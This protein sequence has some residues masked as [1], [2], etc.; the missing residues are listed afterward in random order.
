[1]IDAPPTRPPAARPLGPL[2]LGD[3][4]RRNA[5]LALFQIA[6]GV[7]VVFTLSGLLYLDLWQS[8]GTDLSRLVPESATLFLTT[9]PPRAARA[10][11]LSL[12]RWADP[13]ALERAL[14]ETSYLATAP[15]G[16]VFGVP[17]DVAREILVSTDGLSVALLPTDHG[18]APLLF[19]ELRD[20]LKRRR[21]LARLNPLLDTVDRHVGFR[22]D[23]VRQSPWQRLTGLDATAPRVVAMEPYVIF[24]W[25]GD[26]ALDRVLEARVAGETDALRWRE[27]FE[28]IG[29]V[30]DP[31]R[32]RALIDPTTLWAFAPG[33]TLPAGRL[34]SALSVLAV[35]ADLADRDE[36]L[37]VRALLRDEARA[38]RL[39]HALP[40]LPHALVELAPSDAPWVLSVV[41]DK[42]L[43]TLSMARD[44]L[45]GAAADLG[46]DDALRPTLERLSSIELE[47][48]VRL[49]WEVAAAFAGE[50]AV[51]AMPRAAAGDGPEPGWVI[52]AR[53]EQPRVVEQTLERLLPYI[54]GDHYAFGKVL[55]GDGYIHYV[56]RAAPDRGGLI[57]AEDAL[58]W[59]V[60]DG[61][62]ELAPS[63]AVL[64]RFAV[65]RRS[66]RTYA[67]TGLARAAL[68]KLPAQAAAVAVLGPSLVEVLDSPLLATMARRLSPDFRAAVT[69]SAGGR[70]LELDSNLG[71]W[72]LGTVIA[73]ADK[74]E[75]NAFTLP[76]LSPRCR[77]AHEAMCATWPD[78]VPCQPLVLGRLE[79]IRQACERLSPEP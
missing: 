72:T 65:E 1:M 43:S 31:Q 7:L 54:V 8:A 55:S 57:V 42:P 49:D 46:L 29:D 36:H 12:A 28:L 26:E 4:R 62:V 20:L 21:V 2:A 52:L 67:D 18:P 11:A 15:R 78:A 45:S 47:A 77:A 63:A 22:V 16:E 53:V 17:L 59:R 5:R 24:G 56:R 69:L 9:P 6:I 35:T 61:L 10:P 39:G 27:G 37:Q 23:A 32:I 33:G 79:R 74:A 3:R 71:P 25:G 60:E 51:I 50:M 13:A 44:L 68:S 75:V 38:E 30:R 19:V 40:S 76:G 58:A 48:I 41:T 34:T 73:T 14:D 66:R 64:E 70:W